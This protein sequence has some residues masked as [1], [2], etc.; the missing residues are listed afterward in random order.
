MSSIIFMGTPEFAV[1]A[2]EALHRQ[3]GVSTVVTVPD[4]QKGRGLQTTPSAVKVAAMQL[5]ISDILQPTS[6][7]DEAFAEEIRKRSPL[8]I[9][10]IA[11]RILPRSIYTL[12]SQGAF[13]VHAS[14]LPRFRGAAPINHAIMQGE[15]VS[16][17]TSFLLN[18]VVDTGTMIEQ[19]TCAIDD[20]MTAGDLYAALMPL[21][22]DCAVSTTGKLLSGSYQTTTQDESLA[23]PAPKV[24]REH[25]GIDWAHSREHVRN[26]IRAHSPV[27]AAWTI[28][29]DEIMKVFS[30]ER[31]NDVVP[32]GRWIIQGERLI[33]GC[34]DGALSLLEVQLPGR[35]RMNFADI[36]RGY[37]GPSEGHFS[38]HR[39]TMLPEKHE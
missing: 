6:L 32:C 24:F 38:Q 12:A 28:W 18:D 22:A 4:R 21:A 34:A 39:S 17:V 27:P 35:R 8:V 5:G 23:S 26:F 36:V 30:A 9:C 3:Y 10:V 31:I 25:A 13:N 14:L 11:F 1:P 19:R 2:L 37:R 7:R 20:A 29:N 16:G 15:T 33:A